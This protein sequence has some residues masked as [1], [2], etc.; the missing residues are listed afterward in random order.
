VISS[1]SADWA[2][3]EATKFEKGDDKKAPPPDEGEMPDLEGMMQGM[4]GMQ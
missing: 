3:A 1:W 2:T 4:P